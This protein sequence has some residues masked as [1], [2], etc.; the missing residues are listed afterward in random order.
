MKS[1][2]GQEK[3]RNPRL[4]TD[5]TLEKF[6]EIIAN[7]NLPYPKLIDYTVPANRA[8]RIC[9]SNMRRGLWKYSRVS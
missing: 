6:K 9:P 1:S 7:L 5:I 4:G 3:K 2:I 8:G